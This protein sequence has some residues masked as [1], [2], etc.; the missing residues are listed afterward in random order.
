MERAL[1]RGAHVYGEIVGF[2]QTSDALDVHRFDP[3]GAQYARALGTALAQAGL[4]PDDVDYVN[5][6]G[7]GTEEGDR[8]EARALAR[9]L[10]ERLADVP[11]SAPKSMVGNTLAGAGAIDLAFTLLA[12]RDGLIAPTI[13]LRRQDPEC[14]LNLVAD[15]A[16]PASI[17]V[18]LM[19]SR[20][21]TGVNAALAVQ[22]AG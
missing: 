15:G 7:R 2:A 8:S 12:M 14:R 22:R 9:V 5:A 17:D 11:V 13:N 4:G 18:A 19:G 10:G 3:E 1:A 21:T 16:R 6:D 20:G